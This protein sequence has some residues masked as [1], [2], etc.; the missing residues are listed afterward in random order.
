VW[1]DV[2]LLTIT[3]IFI[4]I[5]LVQS[6]TSFNSSRHFRRQLFIYC[7]LVAYGIVPTAHWVYLNGGLSTQIVE[8]GTVTASLLD[9]VLLITILALTITQP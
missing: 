3:V 9:S 1:R 5:L 4:A 7:G 2:Y 8:V 6:R